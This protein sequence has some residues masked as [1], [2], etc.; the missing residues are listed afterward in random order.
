M[1]S[2]TLRK[3]LPIVGA[4]CLLAF[5]ALSRGQ[6]TA[7]DGI[8]DDEKLL[9]AADVPVD[10]KD[11]LDYLRG[12]VPTAGDE[13]EIEALFRQL[14]SASFKERQRASM[15]LI[16]MGPKMVPVLKRLLQAGPPLEVR[17]RAE[18]C[19]AA[20][21][22]KFSPAVTAAAVRLAK[23]RKPD[24]ACATLL[25]FAPFAPDDMVAEEVLEA[26]TAVAMV[27]KEVEPVLEKALRDPQAKRREIAALLVGRFG[28]PAQRKEVGPLLDDK[29]AAVRFRAA[30]GLIGAGSREALPVLVDCLRQG[31]EVLAELA[32]EILLQAAGITAPKIRFSAEGAQ[33]DKCHQAWKQWLKA[34]Q[35]KVDLSKVDVGM[36]AANATVRARE[37]VRQL[38]DMSLKPDPEKLRAMTELPFYMADQGILTTRKEWDDH[39]KKNQNQKLPDNIKLQ[40]K[41]GK[42]QTVTEYL[43]KARPQEK[44]FLAKYPRSQVRVVFASLDIDFMGN[45]VST[46]IKVFVRV[47]GARARVIGTG[48]PDNPTIKK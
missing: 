24:N 19:M 48:P 42:V 25:E 43:E 6:E 23:A 1:F 40:L 8:A 32:E 28:T 30:Q 33:R 22:K 39:F 11:L 12:Q 14:D 34:H 44:D 29:E 5:H 20:V 13:K 16:A 36:P 2:T 21:H 4:I 26:L 31:P 45:K 47:H 35:A 46:T 10:G 38:L 18:G 27:K 41:A 15:G 17:R 3:Y 37:V 7:N 9:R